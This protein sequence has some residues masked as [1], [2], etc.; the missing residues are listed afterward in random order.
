MGGK[1]RQLGMGGNKGTIGGGR[2]GAAAVA[3]ARRGNFSH[4][5]RPLLNWDWAAGRTSS[6]PGRR[7]RGAGREG[8]AATRNRAMVHYRIFGTILAFS[9]G[10]S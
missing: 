1:L 2:G 9:V 6:C 8:R 3:V 4:A 7:G 10:T 5:K